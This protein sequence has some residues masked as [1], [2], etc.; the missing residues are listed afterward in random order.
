M[1]DWEDAG[2]FPGHEL[3]KK[4]GDAGLL[5]IT[6]EPEYGG[7]GLDYSHSIAFFEEVGKIPAGGIQTA[8]TV[9]TDM[10]RFDFI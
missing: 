5:G 10:V 8:I 6:R 7:L 1:D 3:F 9:H 2:G 4:L